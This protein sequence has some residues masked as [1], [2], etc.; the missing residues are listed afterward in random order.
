MTSAAINELTQRYCRKEYDRFVQLLH[1]SLIVYIC[2]AAFVTFLGF[3]L[4][5][6]LPLNW[7]GIHYDLREVRIAAALLVAQVVWNFPCSVV[8]NFYRIVGDFHKSQWLNNLYQLLTVV[9]TTA[10]LATGAGFVR[11]AALQLGVP[12]VL[13]TVVAALINVQYPDVSLGFRHTALKEIGPLLRAGSSFMVMT[14]GNTISMQGP[15]L[16]I[17]LTLG[18]VFVVAFSTVRT[19]ANS[20]R[21]IVGVF[22]TA[23]WPELTIAQATGNR[24]LARRIHR[25]LVIATTSLATAAG[26]SLWFVGPQIIS[27]WTRTNLPD[28]TQLIRWFAVQVVLQAPW[29]AS[30]CVSESANRNRFLSLL[31][32]GS[33]IVGVVMSAFAIRYFGVVAV[34]ASIVVAELCICSHFVIKDS[35]KLLNEDYKVFAVLLWTRLFLLIAVAL[36]TAW[37]FSLMPIEPVI[38][39]F[40]VVSSGTALSVWTIAWFC[41]LNRAEKKRLSGTLFSIVERVAA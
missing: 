16:V 2:F 19:L 10:G 1:T 12:L 29:I 5:A 11:I 14:V 23:A 26:A 25:G 8:F 3:T 34:P 9:V 40:I 21:Q 15:I 17:S 37:L 24:E 20:V 31:Y 32:T 35:C 22:S 7:V 33:A 30:S 13:A 38:P 36:F 18:P 4:F 27:A 41:W 39:R 28:T 6:R